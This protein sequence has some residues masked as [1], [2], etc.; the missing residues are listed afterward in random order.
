MN[1]WPVVAVIAA[2]FAFLGYARLLLDAPNAK[3][4]E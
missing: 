3:E 2:W 4:E 1:Y